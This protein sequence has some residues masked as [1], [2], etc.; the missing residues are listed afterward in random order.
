MTDSTTEEHAL[1][2]LP[3]AAQLG[4]AA[5]ILAAV[6]ALCWRWADASHVMQPDAIDYA[7][8]GRSLARGDGFATQQIFPRHLAYLVEHD[9]YG[10]EPVPN[11]YRYPIQGAPG[12]VTTYTGLVG[13]ANANFPAAGNIVAGSTW[14]FTHWYRDPTGPCGSTYSAASALSV[15]FIP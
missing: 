3:L 6:F 11:L 1:P 7:Q 5:A 12:G 2:A 14:N 4:V 9:L 10:A 13:Y 15:T 8:M